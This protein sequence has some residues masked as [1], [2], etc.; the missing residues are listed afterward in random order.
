MSQLKKEIK[1][2]KKEEVK[3]I[4][5]INI[6]DLNG[7][8]HWI[9]S[10]LEKLPTSLILLISLI[11]RI[12]FFLFGLYQDANMPLPY[13]DIDYYVFTDAAKFISFNKSPFL[14]ATY[15]YTPLLAWIL[16]PTTY[17]NNKYWFSFGKFIFIICDLITG[18]ISMISLP[19]N[20]KFLSI[21]WLFNPMVI[22]IST[23]G[24]SESL[25][26]LFVLLTTYFLL[27]NNGKKNLDIIISGFLLGFSIHLKIYPFIYTPVFLLYLDSKQNIL[28]PITIKRLIFLI[29]AIISFSIFTFW[30]Y[31]IYGDEYLKE[32]F[33]YHLI[34]LD[35][36]HNFSIYNISLYLN[37]S[38]ETIS[39]LQIEKLS[40]IPQ[41]LLTLIIL[42]LNLSKGFKI[43][44]NNEFKNLLVYKIMFIQTFIFI[45]FN[46]V[47]TSQYFIWFLC[48]LPQYLVGTT[49]GSNIG[50]IYIIGW[51]IT[52]SLWLY[53]G[54]RLEFLGEKDIFISGLFVSKSFEIRS[55]SFTIK[56][57]SVPPNS[58]VKWTLRPLKN[59]INLGI[60][61]QK[62]PNNSNNSNNS[63][64]NNI[65][66]GSS[67]VSDLEN[68]NVDQVNQIPHRLFNSISNKN[69]LDDNLTRTSSIST[70]NNS[71]NHQSIISNNN[72]INNSI[73]LEEKLDCQLSKIQ[74][75][76]KCNGDTLKTAN[77]KTTKGGLYAFVFD[78]TFSKTKAKTV[79]FQY[80]I[81][82]LNLNSTSNPNSNSNS[83]PNSSSQTPPIFNSIDSNL[84]D[85]K[86]TKFNGNLDG[87]STKII[88]IKG[89]QYLEGTLM[90]KKRRNNGAKKFTKRYFSLNLTYSILYYYLDNESNNIRGNMMITQTVVSAD[91]LELMLY[92]DSGMEQWVLKANSK[93]DFDTWVNAFNFVKN[94]N[95]K[96][97]E[98]LLSSSKSSS[99]PRNINENGSIFSD[100]FDEK[101]AHHQEYLNPQFQ[102]VEEKIISLKETLNNFINES[103]NINFY[104]EN[105]VKSSP[106]QQYNSEFMPSSQLES[107]DQTTTTSQISQ[108]QQQQQTTSSKSFTPN[109][110]AVNARKLSRSSGID[111]SNNNIPTRKPS[112]LHRLKRKGSQSVPNTPITPD[113]QSFDVDPS[114]ISQSTISRKN[115]NDSYLSINMNSNNFSNRSQ[116]QSLSSVPCSPL[117]EPVITNNLLTNKKFSKIILDSILEKVIELENEYS[118]LQ[119]QEKSNFERSDSKISLNRTKSILS[120]EFFDAQEYADETEQGVVMLNDSNEDFNL[121]KEIKNDEFKSDIFSNELKE[122]KTII[123]SSTSES[124]SEIDNKINSNLEIKESNSL[125]SNEIIK[126]PDNID[127]YPLPYMGKINFRSDIKP[128]ACEPPSL[129][130]ILRK[131]IGKDMTSMTMPISTNEPL[132]FLQKYTESMEYCNLINDALKSPIETGER[133]LKIAAFAISFLSS[134]KDNVRSIR[135]PFNPLLGETFELVRPDLD[136]RVITEKVIH[137]PFVM[138]AHVDSK[139]WYIEHSISPQQKFYGKTAEIIV[140]GTLKLK[141]RDNDEIYEWNQP[142]TILRN[143]VSLT[144]EKYTEPIDSITIKSNTGYKCVVTFISENGRFTSSRSEKVELKVY[145]DNNTKPI[146]LSA[147]G[148]WT[149]D[150]SLSNGKIIWKISTPLLQHE[151]KYGFTKFSCC[152]NDLDE[153]HKDCA[154]TD[155]RRRPDQ[156][157]YENGIIDDADE[158]K[159]K[160]EEDQRLRR[161][162]V[163]GNDVIHKPMFFQRGNSDLDWTF[164]HG[165]KGYWNRR[166]NKKWDDLVKLW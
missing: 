49:I 42:P 126:E 63:N 98:L 56:W 88:N 141:F 46:K 44:N 12:G 163:N 2:D 9:F 66:S 160:L 113:T 45:M 89:V 67:L 5:E 61:Q 108:Q 70:K 28:Q 144:G 72:S 138:A 125:L 143:I 14:R 52:Q 22:T 11:L 29:S 13:T 81:K 7:E 96:V 157:M 23:R 82:N 133:I 30:M 100:E 74:W 27:R 142:N 156:R 116:S 92:L 3:S 114:S 51:I 78:N 71:L 120:Q 103:N 17:S 95:K 34:R 132:S 110:A 149:K 94:E 134:Y 101:G 124:E 37:S 20:Y 48:L 107:L 129:V 47:C 158:L 117:I 41:L 97:K 84:S 87:T 60:Y 106:L 57:I 162:D 75:I 16:L 73:S 146:S 53:N 6:K 1:I 102:I 164:I 59:S 115:S 112:F 123:S 166:K 18:Y 33:L 161:K 111:S 35:H 109:G 137:K 83:N 10:K 150:I 122:I 79:L 4:K 36:R 21:I 153:I 147:H 80:S 90:K 135:K 99:I 136:I 139:D 155:S 40:F 159:L 76:G 104:G 93:K 68:L 85:P 54:W 119:R 151:K 105:N 15:R 50:I 38:K 25:L 154:P 39:K 19:L 65:I 91:S 121:T 58:N 152:L 131:G 77:I 130:S 64:N 31:L 140:D 148:S 62:Q 32:A 165:D 8:K 43:T 24:S 69:L 118:E 86:I 145:K 26:T 128:A 55:K 127:L